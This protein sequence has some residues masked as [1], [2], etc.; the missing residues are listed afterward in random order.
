MHLH[1]R[2]TIGM[3]E[4]ELQHVAVAGELELGRWRPLHFSMVDLKT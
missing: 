4:E 2:V 3:L 1:L